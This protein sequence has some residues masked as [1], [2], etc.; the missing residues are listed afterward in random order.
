M[1]YYSKNVHVQDNL[2][3]KIMNTN[4]IRLITSQHLILILRRTNIKLDEIILQMNTVTIQMIVNVI[5]TTVEGV[6]M[7]R[8]MD[9]TNPSSN[10]NDLHISEMGI[11]IM[12]MVIGII[13]QRLLLA[14]KNS[15]IIMMRIG[16]HLVEYIKEGIKEEEEEVKMCTINLIQIIHL[17]P[18]DGEGENER[19]T[20]IL[21]NI[22]ISNKPIHKNG[23][24]TSIVQASTIMK[25]TAMLIT[26]I[27]IQ[28]QEEE[29]MAVSK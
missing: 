15:I 3:R 4:K 29:V 18:M 24:P 22:L 23:R 14:L 28:L 7:A 8:K 27:T 26:R 12:R 21:R 13:I 2:Q 6:N 25:I 11:I 16:S 5:R 20:K 19:G 1:S 17:L 9:T 10:I